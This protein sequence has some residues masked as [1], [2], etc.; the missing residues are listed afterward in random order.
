[1][2]NILSIVKIAQIME[3]V[4]RKT[5]IVQNVVRFLILRIKHRVNAMSV[6][7]LLIKQ[8]IKIR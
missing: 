7:I 3:A 5:N 1:M 8:Q 6:D 4:L 2:L